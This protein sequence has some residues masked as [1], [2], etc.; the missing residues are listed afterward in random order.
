MRYTDADLRF[1]ALALWRDDPA[2]AE[3]RLREW[4]AGP[5]AVDACLDDER[6]FIALTA[7]DR[8]VIE[9]SPRFLFTLLLRR[10]RRDRVDRTRG[11]D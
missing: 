7:D 6:V 11:A 4:R 1:L 3:E 10:I 8:A 5:Q 2:A 9:L